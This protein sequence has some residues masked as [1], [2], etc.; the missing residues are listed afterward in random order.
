M[1]QNEAEADPIAVKAEAAR[2]ALAGLAPAGFFEDRPG[3][4]MLLV[5]QETV[6]MSLSM[7]VRSCALTRQIPAVAHL[8]RDLR[9]ELARRLGEDR[10]TQLRG[11]ISS[12]TPP[13]FEAIDHKGRV[14]VSG[15]RP[16]TWTA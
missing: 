4:A 16:D 13:W 10:V 11:S 12:G 1:T 7:A 9:A 3:R 8:L 5:T 2:A 15:E 6:G 14:V